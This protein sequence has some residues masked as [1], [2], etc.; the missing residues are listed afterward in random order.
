ME[1]FIFACI[2]VVAWLL[3]DGRQANP[4]QPGP[5]GGSGSGDAPQ[6]YQD[7]M[8]AL[9]QAIADFESG[10]NPNALNYRNNNPGNLRAGPGMVGTSSGF[11]VFPDYATGSND[12]AIDIDNWIGDH[13]DWTFLQ[14]F[15]NYL[16]G[17]PNG[18]AQTGQGDSS[19]YAKAV[20]A[21]L[22]ISPDSTVNGYLTGAS[23]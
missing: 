9:Q 13:P 22:G 2:G 3:F 1:L 15:A 4:S 17:N 19:S 11:A 6:S 21:S 23:S 8:S 20:A 18:P 14:F 10:G 12:L 5:D 16:T 7:R